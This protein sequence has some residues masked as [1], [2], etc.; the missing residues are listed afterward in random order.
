MPDVDYLDQVRWP[1]IFSFMYQSMSQLENNFLDI[2][3]SLKNELKQ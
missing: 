3:D 1:E 2:H